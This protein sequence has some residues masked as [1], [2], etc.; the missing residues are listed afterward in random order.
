MSDI[1]QESLRPVM[2]P[3]L[4]A[5]LAAGV[6]VSAVLDVGVLSGTDF[7]LACFPAMPH[8][9]FEPVEA[10]LPAI[11][12]RYAALRHV[13]VQVALS[14]EDG[15]AW[16]IGTS[17]DGSGKVTHS[18]L[19]DVPVRVGE[20]PEVVE[21]KPV[22]KARLDTVMAEISH[23]GP[24]LLKV[25]VDGQELQILSGARETLRTVSILIIEAPTGTIRARTEFAESCQ[26]RL[27]DIVD[28][29]SYHG[30][31]SQVDLIFIN[32]EWFAKCPDLSPWQSKS[33]AW[34]AWHRFD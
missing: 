18:E 25:D 21:C 28:P 23:T 30:I 5:L 17:V 9:L 24:Y 32:E 31:L 6:P 20:R 8:V 10:H 22:R 4:E 14:D 12:Q 34:S 29:C 11:R 33:F 13:L 16:Q 2:Q 26:F 15:Q 27:I 19:S 1:P 3:R 7:L